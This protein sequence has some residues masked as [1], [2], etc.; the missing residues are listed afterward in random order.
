M[1]KL[2]QAVI[3]EGRYDKIKLSSIIDA[4]IVEVNGFQIFKDKEKAEL[5]KI[6]SQTCGII[7]M[8]DSDSAGMMIR[9]RLSQIALGGKVYHAYVP[10][11]LGIE[12]RKSKPS[13]EGLLGVEGIE[14]QYIIDALLKCGLSADESK[15]NISKITNLDLYNLGLT[16]G[17]NSAMRRSLLLRMLDLPENISKN[18]MLKILEHL[19]NL[20]QLKELCNKLGGSANGG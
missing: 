14:K 19:I 5:I 2:K 9:N 13:A 1:L 3:V 11:I 16:G 17:K 18:N 20:D 12:R 10:Q 15:T 4:L 8:T 6:L 7:I